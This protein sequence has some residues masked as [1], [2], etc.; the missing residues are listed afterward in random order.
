MCTVSWSPAP[1]PAGGG[2]LL[3]MNRDERRTRLPGLPPRLEEE[4]GLRF[5]APRDADAGGTWLA[6]NEAGLTAGLLNLYQARVVAAPP[7]GRKSRGLL[8]RALA[9]APDLGAAERIVAAEDLAAYQ[10]F[11]LVLVGPEG[12]ARSCAWDGASAVAW[13]DAVPP[14]VS[15]GYD[16]VGATRNREALF[17]AAGSPLGWDQ[18]YAF[19]RGHLPEK[20]AYSTCMHRD[21]AKTVSLTAIRVEPDQVRM[22]YAPGSPCVTPL[23]PPLSLPRT[24]P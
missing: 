10:P 12:R 17:A 8:V 19:H 3:F 9:G 6:V 15:S 5:L 18:L 21:D 11:T 4:G 20:G 13:R 14:I 1:T 2:Y 7:P 23:G 24:V 16:V 22:A